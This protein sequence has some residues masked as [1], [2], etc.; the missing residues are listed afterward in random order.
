MVVEDQ[1]VLEVQGGRVDLEEAVAG[2]AAVQVAQEALEARE[3]LEVPEEEEAAAALQG[4]LVE[5][6]ALQEVEEEGFLEVV[7]FVEYL[8][9]EEGH[10]GEAAVVL[11]P[12]VAVVI[13]VKEEEAAVALEG[14][15]LARLAAE[16]PVSQEEAVVPVV[17][18]VENQHRESD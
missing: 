11:H 15:D 17:S 6:V 1:A 4:E 9:M 13:Q 3:V 2:E 5:E 16:G 12:G 8:E 10:P 18:R 14:E 7:E